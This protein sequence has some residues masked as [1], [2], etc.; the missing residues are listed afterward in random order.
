MSESY[1]GQILIVEDDELMGELLQA[2][3]EEAGFRVTL[4]RDLAGFRRSIAERTY[5]FALMDLF[6]EG[7]SG[8]EGISLLTRESP[9]TKVIIMS[10]HG[11]LELA[12]D[13]ME[14]GASSFVAKGKDPKDLIAALREKMGSKAAR[15]KGCGGSDD[16][17]GII[18]SSPA[19]HDVLARIQQVKD[20]DSTVLINGESGTGKELVARAIHSASNRS[21]ERFEAINCGAIPEN[22]LESE[23]FG[24]K[25]GAFTDAKADRKG[26]FELCH[27]GTLFLDEIGELP[28]ALQVKLLRVLQE[29]QVLP[30]GGSESVSLDTRVIVATN[31]VLPAEVKKGTFRTDLYYR[32]NVIQIQLPPLRERKQDI[33][34]LTEFFLKRFNQRFNKQIRPPSRELEVRLVAHDW[35]GNIRE[36][37]NALERGVVLST[38]GTLRL[39][40]MLEQESAEGELPV[41]LSAQ[42]AALWSGPL[43]EARKTFEKLYLQQLLEVTKGNISEIARISGRYR[44]DVYRLMT[45]Y[46]VEWEE[47]RQAP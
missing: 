23:L 29:R 13:A 6:L 34:A 28:L 7:E 24:H 46:G 14:K 33:P 10:A 40:N 4:V 39:G 8:L 20:I 22:L 31:R 41:G 36:L 47:F 21:G 32:L 37:Q 12:V 45:K 42:S 17:F 15:P 9:Y 43:S 30:L 3:L 2:R 44:A 5:D 19:I 1:S 25:R 26:L 27:K 35:P 18:G 38:D 11:T 16:C